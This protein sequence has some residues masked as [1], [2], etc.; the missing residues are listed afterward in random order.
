MR[1]LERMFEPPRALRRIE[2]LSAEAGRRVWSADD[3]ARILEETLER[4][5]VVSV[6]ARRHGL[7]PQQVFG[8]RREARR[9]L[10]AARAPALMGFVPAVVAEPRSEPAAG[11]TQRSRRSRRRNPAF[12]I[13]LEVSGIAVR[14]GPGASAAQI[15]AVI[16]ALKASA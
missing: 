3:K 9:A 16:R 13:E 7:T 14:V 5:A 1:K 12:G 6:I 4:G 15:V 11:P 2:V 8:W 10:E